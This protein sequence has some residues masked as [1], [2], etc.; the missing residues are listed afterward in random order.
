MAIIKIHMGNRPRGSQGGGE[1]SFSDLMRAVSPFMTP[2]ERAWRPNMDV[3]EAG[4]AY[5]II[6]DVAGMGKDDLSIEADDRSVTLSGYRRDPR[7]EG[8]RYRVAEIEFGRFERSFSFAQT[9]DVKGIAANYENGFLMVR[10]P[11]KTI[12]PSRIPVRE[13]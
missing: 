5:I 8:A 13:L 4:D 3:H 2:Y 7:S 12:Q 11:K 1:P 9:I 6:A 10:L